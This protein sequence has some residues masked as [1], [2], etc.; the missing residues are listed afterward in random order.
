MVATIVRLFL[1]GFSC[2][3]LYLLVRFDL[4]TLPFSTY[5]SLTP[6]LRLLPPTPPSLL[7]S[8]YHR[9]VSSGRGGAAPAYRM[10][11]QGAFLTIGVADGVRTDPRGGGGE[12]MRGHPPLASGPISVGLDS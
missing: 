9:R 8:P 5:L 12:G 6:S 3:F 10:V 2:F 1:V 4:Q 7:P 11:A